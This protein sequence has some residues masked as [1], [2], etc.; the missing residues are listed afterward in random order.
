MKDDIHLANI[1]FCFK[2]RVLYIYLGLLQLSFKKVHKYTKLYEN[3][4]GLIILHYFAVG[5]PYGS[6]LYTYTGKLVP[7]VILT[8]L[9]VILVGKWSSL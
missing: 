5:Y 7:F 4:I 9:F 1:L 2:A 3:T 6:V 8:C